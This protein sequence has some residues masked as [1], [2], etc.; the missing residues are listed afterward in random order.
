[1]SL[2]NG[3]SSMSLSKNIKTEMPHGRSQKQAVVIALD[4]A[5]D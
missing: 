1:M 4:N 3:F 2:K 5:T